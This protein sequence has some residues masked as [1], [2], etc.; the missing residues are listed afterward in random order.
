[1]RNFQIAA[2]L[3]LLGSAAA[4]FSHAR[5]LTVRVN[6]EKGAPLPKV[7]VSTEHPGAESSSDNAVMDQVD[8]LFKPFILTIKPGTAVNFPNSDN[9]RHQVY[10][11]SPAK[12]FEVPLYSN[13]EAPLIT[14]PSAGVVVLGCN[15]H[16]HMRAY[17]YVSPHAQSVPTDAQGEAILEIADGATA[18]NFWYPGLGESATAE[19]TVAVGAEQSS[20]NVTL[21]VTR[22]QQNPPETSP[23]QER[24]NRLKQNVN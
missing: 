18:V 7:I 13:R 1:M 16:D 11:F 10:S 15:I 4:N 9:I 21:P 5:E 19:Y 2:L 20:L 12:T 22:Q 6:D 8:R 14:F 3:F 17:I 24:F 23:L